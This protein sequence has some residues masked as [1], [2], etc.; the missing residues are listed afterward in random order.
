[1]KVDDSGI[2]GPYNPQHLTHITHDFKWAGDISVFKFVELLGK[3]Y[4]DS[5]FLLSLLFLQY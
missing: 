2:S 4:V 1:M 5:E 3:G